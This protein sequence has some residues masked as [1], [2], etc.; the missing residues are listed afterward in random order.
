MREDQIAATALDVEAGAD[1]VECN[2]RAFDVPAGAPRSE[3]RGPRGLARTLRTPDESVE[4][5]AL[6]DA[7]GI[8]AAFGKEL[9]H[10][11]AVVA[12]L[13]AELLGRVG[14]EVDVGELRVV[15]DVRGAGRH[16]LL[17]QLDY[18]VHRFDGADVV[19]R[20]KHTQRFHVLAEES[21]LTH[22]EDDPVLA[23]A[24]GSLEQRVVH[25]GHVL[26]VVDIV[27]GVAPDAVHE[28]ERE[29]RGRVAEVG[30]VVRGDAA[31][32]HR[33]LLARGDGANLTVGCVVQP[34]RRPLTGNGRECGIGPR[35]H[36]AEPSG[37]CSEAGKVLADPAPVRA[38]TRACSA[39]RS[40]DRCR[41][42]RPVPA[43][44]GR[45]ERRA[46]HRT[47]R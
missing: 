8:S 47:P 31:D 3:G 39:T 16:E 34:Q 33:R 12:R 1:A 27:S 42:S 4:R 29:V 13:V 21:R 11:R 26:D 24:I 30:G 15:D 46:G 35:L 32:V 40:S 10:R 5:I 20:R 43:R 25:V 36:A 38:S 22:A 17:H 2:G 41:R 7:F 23:V 18:F 19:L 44:I 9:L 14:T 45:S 6:S 28:V 37:D